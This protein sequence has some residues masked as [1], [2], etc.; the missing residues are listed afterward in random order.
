MLAHAIYLPSAEVFALLPIASLLGR[1]G[2]GNG[3]EIDYDAASKCVVV[4]AGRP[5]R[6]GQEVLL[7]DPRPNGELLMAT[8]TLPN[9]SNAADFLNFPAALIP[10]D[11]YFIMKS[12]VSMMVWLKKI[13]MLLGDDQITH[14]A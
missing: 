2:N 3:S 11:K 14:C 10:A 6:E 1:T 4:T 12:Q 5:Y 7:N 9:E 13:E 8:G